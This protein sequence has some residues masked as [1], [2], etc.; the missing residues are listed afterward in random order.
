MEWSNN[1]SISHLFLTHEVVITSPQNDIYRIHIPS[2]RELTEDPFYYQLLRFL[3]EEQL[4]T[5]QKVLKE[6]DAGEILRR[7]VCDPRITNLKEFSSFSNLLR[8]NLY[9]VLVDFRIE[10][11]RLYAGSS[12]I[13]QEFLTE[14]VYILRLG[15]GQQVE[16]PQHFG[17]DEEQARLFYERAQ[18]AR[19]KATK[20]RSEQESKNDS[21]P[22][23]QMFVIINY[24]FPVYS[25]EQLY[26]M[27][28]A[29]LRYLQQ[30]AA[31]M[32]SYEHNMAAYT[33]GNLKKAPNFFLK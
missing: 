14:L 10:D 12:L 17:P 16:K 26:D 4:T 2:L 20:I 30:T 29:Q 24:K 18:A 11:R 8:Q 31:S 25:I 23:I 9:K 21:D 28:F 32:I 27:T 13:T 15:I 33:A 7:F 6:T 19:R 22:L 1:F 3:D 5:W